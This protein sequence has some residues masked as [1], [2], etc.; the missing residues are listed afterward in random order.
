VTDQRLERIVASL[1]RTGVAL[2]AGTV[3]AGGICYLI[4]HGSQLAAYHNFSGEP[5]TYTRVP[6]IV[7]AVWRWDCLAV[8][9]FGLLILVATPVARVAF[10]LAAFAVEKDHTYV[11]VTAI[12]LAIL[13]FSLIGDH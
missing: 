10:S 1:L 5:E 8:V 11:I 7:S 4:H 3:L 12:V 13:M 2:S 6:A 9:Q